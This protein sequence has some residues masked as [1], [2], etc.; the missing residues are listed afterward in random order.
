MQQTV[1]FYLFEVRLS[2]LVFQ[3]GLSINSTLNIYISS[4][5]VGSFILKFMNER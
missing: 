5:Y 2:W 3:K 1:S 4:Y